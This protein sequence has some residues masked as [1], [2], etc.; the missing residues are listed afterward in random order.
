M[1]NNLSKTKKKN[2]S[3]SNVKDKVVQKSN[4]GSPTLR[5]KSDAEFDY[6]HR[7]K[8]IANERYKLEKIRDW[9]KQS[10]QK[11]KIQRLEDIHDKIKQL[12]HSKAKKSAKTIKR[13]KKD[14]EKKAS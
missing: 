7:L 9:N 6:N 1:V 3:S 5:K 14:F 4:R 13:L 12:E 8:V 2:K 11:N 10:L